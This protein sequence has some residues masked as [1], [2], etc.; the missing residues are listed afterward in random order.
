MSWLSKLNADPIP[1]LLGDDSPD[2]RFQTLQY[3]HGRPA[4]DPDVLAARKSAYEQGAIAAILDAMHP[5]GYW[6]KPGPGY[7][8]N[9]RATTWSILLLAQLGA[10][11]H[12]D[13][14]IATACAYVLEHTL[15]QHGQFSTSGVPSGTVDCLHGNL[16]WALLTLGCTDSRLEQAFQWTA[17]S[18]LGEGIAPLGDSSAV[19]AYQKAKCGPNFACGY[20]NNRSCAWGCVKLLL[21]LGRYNNPHNDPLIQQATQ[22]GIDFLLSID[23]ASGAYPARHNNKPDPR[24]QKFGFPVFYVTDLLQLLDVIVSLGCGSDPRLE[25]AKA[26]ILQK[27]DAHGRWNLDYDYTGKTWASFG[28]LKQPSKWVTLR[29]LRTLK[30]IEEGI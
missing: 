27:Q 6:V 21:A 13:E 29:A 10:S 24:W 23:P 26:T 18:I 4:D 16:S 5:S 15:S 28:E 8:H 30:A 2:V 9:Y 25:H 1:W 22:R 7:S 19:L 3:L 20:N 14:R 11:T 17:R 12:A